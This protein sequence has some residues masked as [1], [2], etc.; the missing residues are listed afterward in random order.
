MNKLCFYKDFSCA[1]FSFVNPSFDMPKN[2][3]VLLEV[4]TTLLTLAV[5]NPIPSVAPVTRASFCVFVIAGELS[6][7]ANSFGALVA[8]IILSEVAVRS[9]NDENDS[10][11][12][13]NERISHNSHRARH[14]SM[15]TMQSKQPS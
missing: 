11:G 7:D 9:S 8:L 15:P 13:D 14:Q 3:M 4:R 12:S 6:A 5:V 10:A 1:H 2:R